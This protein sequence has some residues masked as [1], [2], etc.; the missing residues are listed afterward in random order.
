MT[1]W[2][3]NVCGSE[4]KADKAPK[5]C[6]KTMVKGGMAAGCAGCRMCGH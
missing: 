2:K 1:I 6:G 5:C 4:T 3:C